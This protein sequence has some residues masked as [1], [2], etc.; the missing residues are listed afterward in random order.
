MGDIPPHDLHVAVMLLKQDKPTEAIALFEQLLK[1]YPRHIHVLVNAARAFV[2]VYDIQR[3]EALVDRLTAVH[4]D[5]P[6]AWI[7]AGQTLMMARRP[8]QATARFK[9]A[10]TLPDCPSTART[11]LARLLERSHQLEEAYELVSQTTESD[12]SQTETHLLKGRIERRRSETCLAETSLQQAANDANGPEMMRAEAWAELARLYDGEQQYDLAMQAMQQSK[13]LLQPMFTQFQNPAAQ[14]AQIAQQT[15]DDMTAG[16]FHR[17]R[18]AAAP[19]AKK[20]FALLTGFP[21]S[22]TTLLEQVLDSHE[23]VVS[24]DE[25]DVMSRGIF[26]S[27]VNQA[28]ADQKL[29]DVYEAL[30]T[31]QVQRE[32]EKYWRCSEQLLGEPLGEQLFI[33]KNPAHN[34][35]IP[36]TLR[37]FPETKLIV[38][39]RD[40][41]DVVL[42]C[43][44]QFLTPGPIS[45]AFTS[46]GSA[47]ERYLFDM[48]GWLKLRSI[49][50]SQWREFRYEDT[51]QNVEN[52]AREAL[53]FLG[54]P[55]DSSVLKFHEHAR[56][57]HVNSPTY[58]D[59][60]GKVHDA[61]VGRWRNYE[62]YMGPVIEKLQPIMKTLGY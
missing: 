50:P 62:R 49:I 47:V 13:Q 9:R 58:A 48:Q 57:K 54:L 56:R 33:D 46:L 25:Q 24:G 15:L 14:L 5:R 29:L 53:S 21:R 40:P 19:L 41:R 55:W 28:L 30:N 34:Y 10:L 26:P 42:S 52:V 2:F 37:L 17:W 4:S 39:L 22:G 60:S 32:R 7:W 44:M 38:A 18:K 61:A 20:Q 59:V 51:V 45:A 8:V 31:H 36:L 6:E 35:L 11:A 3:A 1:Q 43:Y 12:S 23:Q 27:Y 16:H